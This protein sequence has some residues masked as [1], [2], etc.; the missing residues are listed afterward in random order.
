MLIR[1]F[2]SID[3]I[4]EELGLLLVDSVNSGASVGFVPPFNE[5]DALQYWLQVEAELLAEE[6]ILLVAMDGKK[7]VGSVQLCLS[8]KSNGKHRAEVEKLMVLTSYR[9]K[10]ISKMLMAKLEEYALKKGR[11]LLVLDTRQGDIASNLY[12]KLGYIEAGQIPDF[13]MSASGKLA[14][15]V[16]FYK[17]LERLH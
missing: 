4:A 14:P 15:T 6:K 9:G 12:N 17:R 7:V 10:G 11:H 5:T 13:A 2:S 1:F 3:K 16:F 8:T